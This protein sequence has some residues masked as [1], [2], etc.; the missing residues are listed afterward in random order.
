M[1]RKKDKKLWQVKIKIQIQPKT[2]KCIVL[3]FLVLATENNAYAVVYEG[4]IKVQRAINER[5]TSS[6]ELAFKPA[7]HDMVYRH[8]DIGVQMPALESWRFS[9]HFRG[10]DRLSDTRQ[11]WREKRFY[12]QAEKVISGA[13]TNRLPLFGLKIRSRLESRWRDSKEHAYRYRLRL[14]VKLKR[15]LLGRL[16]PF[17]SNEFYYDLKNDEYNVNRFDIGIDFGKLRKLKHRLYVK[18]K[19]KRKDS[20]WRTETSLVYKLDI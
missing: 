14:N 17:V 10:I 2:A 19:S 8:F 16:K 7:G 13:Q 6:A 12:V 1:P 5:V 9:I 18:F 20:R 4:K 11:W 3:L 15:Q